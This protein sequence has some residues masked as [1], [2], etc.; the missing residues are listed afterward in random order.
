MAPTVA[1]SAIQRSRQG[2]AHGHGQRQVDVQGAKHKLKEKE[3]QDKRDAILSQKSEREQNH[4]AA[5]NHKVN[6][7]APKEA[8]KAKPAQPAASTT[9]KSSKDEKSSK[10]NGKE[11]KGNPELA[12]I[13]KPLTAFMLYSAFRRV[14]LKKENPGKKHI[15]H[16]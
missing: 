10:K 9:S 14:I 1:C 2:E 7:D 11:V 4:S 15:L 5:N 13:K 3:K 8:A 6:H 16:I 12:G